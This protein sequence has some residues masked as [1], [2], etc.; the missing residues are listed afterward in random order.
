MG[1]DIMQYRVAIG[2]FCCIT[3]KGRTC[4]KLDLAVLFA[5]NGLFVSFLQAELQLMRDLFIVEWKACTVILF[6][7]LLQ[8]QFNNVDVTLIIL[9]LIQLAGDVQSNP[10]PTINNANVNG[11]CLSIFH[12]NVGSIRNKLTYLSE[13]LSDFDIICFTET[14][15]NDC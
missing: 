2:L 13:Y 14:H 6:L 15:L 10:G 1:N 5:N 7:C 3:F 8:C 4:F 12:L 11:N 9:L